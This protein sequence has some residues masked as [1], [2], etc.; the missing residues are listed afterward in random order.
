[1]GHKVGVREQKE[2]LAEVEGKYWTEG[3][4]VQGIDAAN[5]GPEE[6]MDDSGDVV[7]GIS[8]KSVL[9]VLDHWADITGVNGRTLL[10]TSYR[11]VE[12][13]VGRKVSDV[14]R[15]VGLASSLGGGW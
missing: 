9:A 11:K 14:D 13:D 7:D 4:A 5:R 15:V 6:V 3:G 1:V 8:R 12:S 10:C 2:W